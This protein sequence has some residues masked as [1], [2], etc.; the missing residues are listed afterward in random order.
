M[1]EVYPFVRIAHLDIERV[2]LL[3]GTLFRLL[4]HPFLSLDALTE[5]YLQVFHQGEHAVFRRLREVF[6]YIDLTQC[7]THHALCLHGRPFPEREHLLSSRHHGA[8]EVE[9]SLGH[10]VAEVVGSAHVNTPFHVVAIFSSRYLA[11]QVVDGIEELRLSYDHLGD[12]L[13]LHS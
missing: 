2:E 6:L 4:A 9:V 11:H 3:Y 13:C 7:L 12:V 1:G 5:R 8:E 10:L